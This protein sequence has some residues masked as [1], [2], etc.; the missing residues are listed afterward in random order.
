MYSR[1]A[2][3]CGEAPLNCDAKRQKIVLYDIPALTKKHRA[4]LDEMANHFKEFFRNFDYS[5]KLPKQIRLRGIR[6][7]ADLSQVL[8]GPGFYCIASTVSTTGNGCKLKLGESLA[9]IVYRGHS[10]T[11]R[12]RIESHLF[13]DS[14][15]N[16][17]SARRF[18]VCL[19][20][21]GKNINIDRGEAAKHEWLVLTH[22]MPNSKVLI[23][24]AAEVGFDAAFGRPIGSDRE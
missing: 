7:A 15:R 24:E 10:H 23:R 3:A 22:S 5:T 13:Y 21:D 20:L 16:R 19:K 2:T 14:Y 12:E 11:V 18:T 9:T 1:F 17:D 4:C 8:R 6:S